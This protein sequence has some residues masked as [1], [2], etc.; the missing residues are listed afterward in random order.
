MTAIDPTVALPHND[1]GPGQIIVVRSQALEQVSKI[2]VGGFV[3][4]PFDL[5]D[6][7]E[8]RAML[9]VVVPELINE[10]R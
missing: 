10:M 1:V 4:S 6:E 2:S 8:I 7:N 9:I 3:A 5:T